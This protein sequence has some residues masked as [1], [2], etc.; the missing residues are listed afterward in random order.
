MVNTIKAGD[1]IITKENELY[2]IM[3]VDVYN[4]HTSYTI[5]SLKSSVEFVESYSH[6]YYREIKGLS[7]SRLR[8]LGTIV[9][10]EEASKTLN[11]LY[12]S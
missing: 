2:R 6:K 5:K 11:L 1:Y 3:T 9:P 8:H 7:H 12:E 10:E 4:G